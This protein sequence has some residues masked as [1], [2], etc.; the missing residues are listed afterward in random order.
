LV[1]NAFWGTKNGVPLEIAIQLA[2]TLSADAW[3][4]IPVA[5]DDN[6]ITQMATLVNSQLSSKLKAYVEF[7]NEVWNSSFSQCA[8]AIAKGKIV[9]PNAMNQ[10]YGGNE[11]TGM[12]SAQIGDIWY[13]VYGSSAFSSRVVIVMA[14]QAANS[15]VLQL[16]LSTPDW[17]GTGNGPASNHHIGAAAIAPYFMSLPSASDL[18][19]MLATSDEGVSELLDAAS[20]QGKY[21]SVP[22]GG[23][24]AQAKAWVES[25]AKIAANY[26]IPLVAYEGGQGLEGFPKYSNG[27]P[28]VNLFLAVNLNNGIIPV[29][30]AYF[31]AWKD[32]GGTLFMAFNDISR[33]SQYGEW[34]A[35]QSVMQTVNP[36]S[37]APPRWQALQ[38][39]IASTP[40]WWS[41]CT[42]SIVAV[43]MAPTN[44]VVK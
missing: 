37:S 12:R 38:D 39:F 40:C 42:G 14:G 18:S 4:N 23:Y 24:I 7:S 34:G 26:G 6:Y 19:A 33:Y 11:W 20:A 9:F 16:E 28:Q 27:S 1:T 5:A 25:N 36:L 2:N 22:T 43:P 17:T 29:Y 41:N 3:L 44:L 32:A 15:N 30:A 35:L 31:A 21:T 13:G 10:W 8:Y